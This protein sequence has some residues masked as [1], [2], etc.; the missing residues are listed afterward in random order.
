MS[1]RRERGRN[2]ST[3][4]VVAMKPGPEALGQTCLPVSLAFQASQAFP[5]STADSSAKLNYKPA[6]PAHLTLAYLAQPSWLQGFPSL[7]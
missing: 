5:A 1:L 2:P 7:A 6:E 4:N 3:L